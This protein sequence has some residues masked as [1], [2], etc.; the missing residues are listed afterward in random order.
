MTPSTFSTHQAQEHCEQLI[1]YAPGRSTIYKWAENYGVGYKL[2]S[3]QW[4]FYPERLS[5]FLKGQT[6]EGGQG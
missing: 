1:G 2:P 6:A 4:R 5:A 3:G